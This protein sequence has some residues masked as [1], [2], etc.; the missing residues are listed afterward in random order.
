MNKKTSILISGAAALAF[1]AL[2][3]TPAE[4]VPSITAGTDN[5]GSVTPLNLGTGNGL[6]LQSTATINN[7]GNGINN[8]AFAGGSPTASGV[9][10]GSVASA[11]SPYPN[12]TF[13]SPGPNTNYLVAE[14]GGSVTITWN[15][16]QNR[17]DMI[18]GTVDGNVDPNYNVVL[19]SAVG[20]E[21]IRGA[22]IAAAA[23]VPA[24]GT[25]NVWAQITGLLPFTVATFTS[26]QVAFEFNVGS[27]VPEPGSLALLGTALA[28]LGFLMSR[29]RRKLA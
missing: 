3:G 18:W 23:G 24:N 25:V 12:G 27:P 6:G 22:A 7:P 10:S 4:A 5:P 26:S 21:I 17:L 15:T 2:V 9:Y 28:G 29:R 11:A 8:I 13:V 1:L 16:N 19:T 14:P 20:S